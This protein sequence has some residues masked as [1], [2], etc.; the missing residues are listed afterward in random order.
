MTDTK[1]NKPKAFTRRDHLRTNELKIQAK[2]EELKIFES[3]AD[4]R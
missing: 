4:E 3:N 2:W 1:D